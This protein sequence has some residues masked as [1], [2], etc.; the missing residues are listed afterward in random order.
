MLNSMLITA[1]VRTGGKWGGSLGGGVVIRSMGGEGR[2]VKE[3]TAY[4]RERERERERE[5]KRREDNTCTRIRF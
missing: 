5:E 1:I 3:H 4:A 2:G